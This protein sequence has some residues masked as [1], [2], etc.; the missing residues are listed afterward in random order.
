MTHIKR[1]SL[2]LALAL[3]MVMALAGTALA[4]EPPGGGLCG[5]VNFPAWGIANENGIDPMKGRLGPWNAVFNPAGPEKHCDGPIEFGQ[6][7]ADC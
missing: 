5:T 3:I 1:M 6:D 7:D 2:A 4:F